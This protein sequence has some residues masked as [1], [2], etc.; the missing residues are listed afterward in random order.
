VL[1]NRSPEVRD[2]AYKARRRPSGGPASVMNS[3]CYAPPA[4]PR[5]PS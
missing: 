3:N 1:S 5:G 2:D 4:I